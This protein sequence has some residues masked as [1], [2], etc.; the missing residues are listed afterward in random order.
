MLSSFSIHNIKT[1]KR[2]ASREI[3]VRVVGTVLGLGHYLIAPLFYIVLYTFVFS[4]IF[5]TKWSGADVGYGDF[6]LRLYTGLIPF[7]FFSEVLTR[8]PN[9]AM[10]NTSYIKKV[11]FPLEMLIPAAIGTA[12]FTALLS[13]ALLLIAYVVLVGLPPLSILSLPVLWVPLI[14]G[15]AGIAWLLSAIGVFL[16]DLA[17]L[18]TTFTPALMFATPIFY[19]ITAVPEAFR[20]YIWLNPLSYFVETMRAALFDGTWPD[21]VLLATVYGV[22]LAVAAFGLWFFLRVKKAFADVV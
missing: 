8:S 3:Q 7:Q 4:S 22:A 21:P 1:A 13:Y 5:V 19:P 11:V 9:L 12:L 15:M 2:I 6:A 16:R 20:A 18:V 14:V 10:E 17:Q